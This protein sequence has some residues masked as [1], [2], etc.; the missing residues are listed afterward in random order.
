MS[1]A[2]CIGLDVHKTS[3]SA[4]VLCPN[5]KAIMEATFATRA[6]AVLSFVRGVDGPLRITF[7]EGTHSAWLF[8]VLRPHA[9]EV[10]VCNPRRN[11]LLKSGNKSDHIDARKLAD[12]LRTGMIKPV[13]HGQNS[14]S[15]IKELARTYSTLTED[16]TRVM[17]RLKAVFRSQALPTEGKKLYTRCRREQYL[18]QLTHPG[19]R[20]RAALFYEQLDLLQQLRRKAR[21][22][23]L[24]ECRKHAVADL[25]KSVPFIGP[26]RAAQLIARVQTPLRF[27]TKRQ[28][29]AYCGLAL[30]TRSS[31]DYRMV[32]GEL[33]RSN[34]PIF[35]RGLN[36][37]HNHELKNVF[38]SAAT[39]ASICEGPFREFYEK[40]LAKGTK[41]DMARL[42]LAR[43]IAAIVL[44]IWKKGERFEEKHLNTQ[45][46]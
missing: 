26:I 19:H 44:A 4:A 36:W 18:A 16:T 9:A 39:T 35:V 31:A 45:A 1:D 14:V 30:E 11:A 37:N 2:K 24:L 21:R 3:I 13:Y 42:T 12:L 29:W 17:G 46:V 41:P 7:E 32:D 22:D 6:D 27:R 5:G 38:K 20:Y 8:E 25:L 33:R 15:S 40:L 43:K 10:V 34:K 23:L 28:F